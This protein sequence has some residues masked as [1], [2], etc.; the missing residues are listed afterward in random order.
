M[1]ARVFFRS[2]R[3]APTNPT[4]LDA[5]I[6]EALP[7]ADAGTRAI[8][9]GVAGL[10]GTVSYADRQFSDQEKRLVRELLLTIVGIGPAQADAILGELETHIIV[11]A[12]TEAPRFS[13][14]LMQHGDRELRLHVL[15]MLLDVAASDHSLG[16]EEVI[17]LRQ[18]TRA[19][20]LEQA[21]YNELQSKHRDKLAAL[22][23]TSSS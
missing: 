22:Q 14:L 7:E 4:S 16:N 15:D 18:I 6:V 2:K 20:G 21:D 8:V 17:L 11:V 23:S 3:A 19:L 9:T 12:T 13:R 10:F 1:L 5:V